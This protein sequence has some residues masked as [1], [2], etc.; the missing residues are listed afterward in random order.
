MNNIQYNAAKLYLEK[1]QYRIKKQN[2]NVLMWFLGLLFLV[3][4]L[5]FL[6]FVVAL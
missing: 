1:N 4:V 5:Y 3:F 2:S 6:K